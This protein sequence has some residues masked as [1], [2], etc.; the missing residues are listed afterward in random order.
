MN[1]HLQHLSEIKKLME[2]SSRFIS[3]SGLSGIFIGSYA[4]IAAGLAIFKI[5]GF[6]NQLRAQNLEVDGS[7]RGYEHEFDWASEVAKL[8]FD[9]ILIASITL[10]LSLLTSY[11]FTQKNCKKNNQSLLDSAAL[12]LSFQFAVPL[13]VCGMMTLWFI[14]NGDYKY[15]AGTMLVGYGMSLVAASAY[16][17]DEVKFLG[18]LEILLGILA[19]YFV[20]YGLYFWAL[21]FG[22]FHIIYG[23]LLYNRYERG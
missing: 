16:T 12:R 22:V 10:V 5:N 7:L 18:V 15:L 4:L 14:Q 9:L 1:D 3:L 21:G 8:K 20:P 19:F 23:I 17:F 2:R 6:K 11:Y 13:V